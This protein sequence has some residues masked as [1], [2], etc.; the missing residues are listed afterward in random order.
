ME[1]TVE[2]KGPIVH[3]MKVSRY[4]GIR[5]NEL[6][7]TEA[8]HFVYLYMVRTYNAAGDLIEEVEYDD[9]GYEMQRTVNS[10]NERGHLVKQENWSDG[11]LA[12]T[13]TFVVDEKGVIASEERAFEEGNP[14]QTK[15][16]YN[17]QG[18]IIEKIVDDGDGELE[19]REV[20]AYHATWT[21]KITHHQVFDEENKLYLE[22]MQEWEERETGVKMKQ[23]ITKDHSI[24][25]SSRIEFFDPRTRE[26]GIAA[27]T[28]NEKDKVTDIMR[29]KFDEHG[30]EVEE[31]SESANEKDNFLIVNEYDEE[32]RLI[33]Q[34]TI[35][36]DLVQRAHHRRFNSEGKVS[37]HAVESVN[38][39]Y[40]DA[41]D[42]VYFEG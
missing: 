41:I 16:T 11:V 38:G 37:V 36:K 3:T 17:E 7:D 10:Y 28:Y 13:N 25:L 33:Y 24:G 2:Q 15:C 29:I 12:E 40:V 5:I 21:D 35:Q 22:E 4:P 14:F 18:H 42:Y 32:G 34:E 1:E 6:D 30:R 26:D 27:V 20:W 39:M 31:K 19:R 23:L 9:E 8:K